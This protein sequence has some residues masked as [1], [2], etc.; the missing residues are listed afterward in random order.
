M[1]SVRPQL[2]LVTGAGRGFGAVV[3][4]RLAGAGI[5]VAALGRN[6]AAI[7]AIADETGGLSVIADVLD[8]RRVDEGVRALVAEHG[9][10][11][12][13]VN[14][15]GVGGTF[16]LAW[17]ADRDAWWHTVEVNVR[18]T[19]NV[20]SA[21]VPSMVEAGAGRIINV[22][23]HAGTARWPYSSAYVVSKAGVIKYGENLAAEVRRLGVKVFNYHPG[24][25]EIGLTENFFATDPQPGTLEG[26]VADWF[27]KQIAEGRSMDAT[28]SAD[29]LVRLAWGDADAL[30]GRYLTAY[31]DL[32]ELLS[33]STEIVDANLYTLGLLEP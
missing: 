3:A 6:P 14:N 24:I 16:G 26:M 17:E 5:R 29:K 22:V 13:L 1:M 28:V 19:H 21:V 32:D 30:S 25:L 33:R 7:E 11:G 15:A 23:S 10:I 20:T 4:R 8:E 18:G 27:R 9:P 2:A 12:V 31:D